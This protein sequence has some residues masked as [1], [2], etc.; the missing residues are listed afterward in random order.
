MEN[1]YISP[2][3]LKKFL[4]DILS[5]K[6]EGRVDA[7]N[8]YLKDIEKDH[9]TLSKNPTK[10]RE[11]HINNLNSYMNTAKFL[12]FGPSDKSYESESEKIDIE[13]GRYD[14]DEAMPMPPPP[15]EDEKPIG[16]KRLKIMT[17]AQLIT[18]LP[19]LLAQIQTGK[20]IEK[21]K[22]EIRQILYSLYRLKKLN[23]NSL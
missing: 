15:L 20:N 9:E 11:S 4:K 19:F 10:K 14:A 7:A 13:T 22:N 23:Q 3:L 5:G 1:I 12:V 8:R 17:P 16:G 2:K 18:R 21:L 6:S